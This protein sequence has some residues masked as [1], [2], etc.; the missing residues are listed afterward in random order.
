MAKGPNPRNRDD[1]VRKLR[2]LYNMLGSENKNERNNAFDAIIAILK[3]R[4][5]GTW[6]WDDLIDLIK[7][8]SAIDNISETDRRLLREQHE[9]LGDQDPV[10]REAAR[11]A[12]RWTL[13]KYRLGWNDLLSAIS[14]V[15][16]FDPTP[17][18][19]ALIPKPVD[20]DPL[21][22][23]VAFLP[24][25]FE[26]SE[27]EYVIVACWA[28]HTLFYREFRVTP[29]LVLASPT[30]GCGKSGVLDCLEM[31]TWTPLKCDGATPASLVHRVD[32]EKCTVL[33]DEADNLDWG[34]DLYLKR[35]LN[36]GYSRKGRVMKMVQGEE[37][38]FSTHAPF[39]IATLRPL[40][41]P[42]MQRSHVIKLSASLNDTDYAIR[43]ELE[44]D[45][46]DIVRQTVF[47]WA[48]GRQLDHNPAIPSEIRMRTRDNWRCFI[49]IADACGGEWPKRVRDIAIRA[50]AR[51]STADLKV[52][53]LSD[54][55]LIFDRGL[56]PE[57]PSPVNVI[58]VKDLHAVLLKKEGALWAAFKGLSETDP[59]K[60]LT[61]RMLRD[62]LGGGRG[63]WSFGIR[64]KTVWLPEGSPRKQQKSHEGY[65]RKQFVDAWARYLRDEYTSTQADENS[66]LAEDQ[67]PTKHAQQSHKRQ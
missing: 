19:V 7:A 58:S 4:D 49:A 46:F 47:E 15:G 14:N 54:I 16:L 23:L 8:P 5:P 30:P 57:K 39:A 35:I 10:K 25:Y 36:G 51:Y 12:I 60:Q 20:P 56:D 24:S 13:E 66:D 37:R 29:R 62:L 41:L 45:K 28:L 31:L 1:D 17:S 43:I 3:R 18:V 65:E 55:K 53:L 22:L 42:L 2:A 32:R 61:T 6:S 11:M 59:P 50:S 27:D 21:S 63:P 52:I 26:V 67:Q 64:A 40:P 38:W 44:T 9:L 33:L 34:G 48:Q